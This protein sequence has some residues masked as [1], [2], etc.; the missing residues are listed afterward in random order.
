MS[1][2]QQQPVQTPP[3][4]KTPFGRSFARSTL[5]A[6][7][8]SLLWVALL[9]LVIVGGF[10][11]YSTTTDFQHR[12]SSEVVHVLE[13]ATGGRVELHRLSFN[14]WQLAIEADGLVI[15]GTEAPTQAPYL[16]ADKILIHVKILSFLSHTAGAGL[17]SHIGLNLLRVEHPQFHLIIDKDGKTNQPVPKHPRTSKTPLSDTLLDLKAHQVEVVSGVALLN[18]R[19][20][21]FDMAARDLEAEVHYIPTSD[22]YGATIDLND[23]RTRMGTNPEVQSRC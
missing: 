18:D 4:P 9:L 3:R 15:H 11:W 16:S 17:S 22:R 21:P 5:K 13:D 6:V 14:L 23:L 12:V 2:P 10:A 8:S 7:G 20:I 1:V 19:A